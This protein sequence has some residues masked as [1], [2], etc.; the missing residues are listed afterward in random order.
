MHWTSL[1]RFVKKRPQR[2]PVKRQAK[3]RPSCSLM[4]EVL[5]AHEL[6]TVGVPPAIISVTPPSGTTAATTMPPIKVTFNEDVVGANVASNYTIFDAQGNSI[7]VGT[8]HTRTMVVRG[9]CHH[10][11]L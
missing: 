4:L 8:P 11:D 10:V 5:E 2:Q 1:F 6:L 7:P 9:R 3:Q